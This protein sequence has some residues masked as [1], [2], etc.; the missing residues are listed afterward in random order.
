MDIASSTLASAAGSTGT[1]ST[2]ATDGARLA[3]DFDNFLTLL[4]TQLQHQ[5]PMEPMDSNEFVNQLVSFTQVEQAIKSNKQLESLLS[6]QTASQAMGALNYM[7]RTVE[8]TGDTGPLANGQ[9]EFTY[10]L[11]SVAKK[12]TLIAELTHTTLMANRNPAPKARLISPRPDMRP[13]VT[14][15]RSNATAT[16]TSAGTPNNPGVFR[17]NKVYPTNSL[18]FTRVP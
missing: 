8:A 2:A 17:T 18:H 14:P 5:D 1:T 13:R 12:T 7:G 15:R 3:D 4:T 16:T 6:M 10:D 11:P 9:A